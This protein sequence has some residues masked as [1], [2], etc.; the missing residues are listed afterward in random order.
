MACRIFST[1]AKFTENIGDT[2]YLRGQR[3]T[4][5]G[6]DCTSLDPNIALARAVAATANTRKVILITHEPRRAANFVKGI[7]TEDRIHIL[8]DSDK[9]GAIDGCVSFRETCEGNPKLEDYIEKRVKFAVK[10]ER[11]LSD[12]DHDRGY[13]ELVKPIVDNANRISMPLNHDG[14]PIRDSQGLI[15]YHVRNRAGL[16]YVIHTAA[17]TPRGIFEA[18]AI[19]YN[20]EF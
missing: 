14:K 10:L 12:P 8:Y 3:L 9:Y 1:K 16:A 18:A 2:F 6:I 15:L 19:M 20:S 11:I 7:G 13:Y 5:L 4:V 17:T